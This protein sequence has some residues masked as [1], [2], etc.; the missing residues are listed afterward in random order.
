MTPQYIV[1]LSWLA[2]AMAVCGNAAS[3]SKCDLNLDST[4]NIADVQ[5][6]VNE[7]L[8]VT[9]AKDDLNADGSVNVVDVQIVINAALGLGCAADPA[10]KSIAPNTGQ[11]GLSGINVTITGSLTSFTSGSAVSLGAGITVTN[12][13]ASGATK[14]TA[15]LTVAANAAPGPRDLTVDGLTLPKAFTVTVPGTV[16]YT[17]DSQGRLATTTYTSPAGS[18]TVVTYSYD[19][20]GN[21]TSVVAR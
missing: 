18:V 6:D 7:A 12:I 19:A 9:L 21:R 16:A 17:Y 10:I 11:Q 13:A 5:L 4:T 1:R 14:I 8:G 3:F 2:A 15:T 20:A